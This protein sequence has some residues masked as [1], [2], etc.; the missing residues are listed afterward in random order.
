MLEIGPSRLEV[1]YH[2]LQGRE[3]SVVTALADEHIGAWVYVGHHES[4][5]DRSRSS[6]P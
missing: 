5:W 4:F 2:D 3:S 1:G 6:T